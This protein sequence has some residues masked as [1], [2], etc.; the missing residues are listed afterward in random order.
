ML[1]YITAWL[2]YYYPSDYMCAIL[3]CNEQISKVPELINDCKEFGIKILPPK[4]NISGSDFLADEKSII[5]GLNSVKGTK[6]N[7]INMIME[8]RKK[9]RHI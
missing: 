7:S 4:V 8:E 2:K 5:F 6:E 3:N 9:E 1:S